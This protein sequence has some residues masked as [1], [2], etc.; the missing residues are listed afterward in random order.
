MTRPSF[1]PDEFYIRQT[2]LPELGVSGQEKLRRSKVAVVGLGGL[3]SA[4]TLYLALAGVGYLRLVDQDTV[5]LHN[6]HRQMLYSIDNLR[7]PKVEVA[8]Q[9]IER[10]NPDVKV[11]PVPENVHEGNVDQVIRGVDCVV[12]GLDNMRTRYLLNRACVK[13]G[14]PYVFGAAIGI[15]GNISVF[16][17]PETPCLECVLPGLDDSQLPTCEVRG[18]LGATAGTIGSM[19]AMETIKLLAGMGDSLKGKLM[20][21]DFRDMYFATIEIFKR[22]DCPVCQVKDVKP[23]E[24]VERLVWLC[25]RNTVNVN[26]PKPMDMKLGEIYETLKR[27]FRILVKSSLVI[28]FQYNGGVEVSVFNRGRMLIKNV[29]DEK[30]ALR[31]YGKIMEKLGVKISVN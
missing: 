21:C 18:V 14:I 20:V 29:K 2:V 9:R 6:L 4:S 3:G 17:P 22:L 15:E 11:E 10:V 27:H 24:K 31:V 28:V 5:E 13:Y 25:G 8:A 30:S 7:Y 23:V 12:D 1:N 19:Q 26:P 16:A